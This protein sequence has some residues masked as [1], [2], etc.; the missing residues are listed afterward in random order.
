M[1]TAG[2]ADFVKLV[3]PNDF[4]LEFFGATRTR[5]HKLVPTVCPFAISLVGEAET[6]DQEYSRNEAGDG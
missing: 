5:R 3:R 2:L 4:H 6:R 1:L